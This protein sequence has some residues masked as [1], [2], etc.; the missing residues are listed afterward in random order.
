MRRA[1][2]YLRVSTQDQTTANQERELREVALR[3]GCEIVKVYKDHGISGAKGRDKRPAFDALCRDAAQRKFDVVMAWSVDRLGR[4]LQDLVGFL[5]ELH[6]LKVDLFLHQQGLDTTTPAGKAMFQM[7]G[8]FA[9][10]ERAII[11][12]R[13]RAGLRRARN[14]GIRL[15]RPRIPADLEKR[16][17]AALRA[18]GRTEGVRKIAARFGVDP[19]TVQRISR[20]F[21][22]TGVAA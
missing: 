5:S 1:A 15:G 18:P 13:V 21:D 20:P 4:S 8:V 11:Q 7:M 6:A 9:E 16:I 3:M 12:E 17:L 2:V 10:F 22:G 14:E 19:G